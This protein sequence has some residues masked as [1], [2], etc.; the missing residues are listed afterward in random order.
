MIQMN[1]TVGQIHGLLL[2]YIA[3]ATGHA[4]VSPFANVNTRGIV[5]WDDPSTTGP[6]TPPMVHDMCFLDGAN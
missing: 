6:E 4:S 5:G 2:S 1:E 3:C